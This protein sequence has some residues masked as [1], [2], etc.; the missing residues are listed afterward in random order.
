[1]LGL[2]IFVQDGIIMHCFLKNRQNIWNNN[3]HNIGYQEWQRMG[4]EV[5]Y[6][7]VYSTGRKIQS[8]AISLSQGGKDS[9]LGMPT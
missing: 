9:S 6:F 5:T 4:N 7:P 1:M 2:S 3:T 8:S